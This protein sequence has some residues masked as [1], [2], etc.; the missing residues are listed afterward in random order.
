ML[1]TYDNVTTDDIGRRAEAWTRQ[2]L[3]RL[4]DDPAP[5]GKTRRLTGHF[6]FD[7]ILSSRDGELYPLECNARVHTAV[8]L[9][10]LDDIAE[11]YSDNPGSAPRDTLRPPHDSL[12]RSW[13]YNDLIMRYLPL[14]IP[15]H[16]LLA[17]LH[18]SLPACLLEYRTRH[19]LRPN[20]DPLK[21][22]VDPTLVADDWLPFLVLWHLWWP[23]VLMSRWWQGKK[24]TRVSRR[25]RRT[26][27]DSS[28]SA[29]HAQLNVSTGRIFEA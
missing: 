1:M 17:A 3:A 27:S 8:I 13:I 15:S 12:P 14:I 24:W 16:H 26:R 2:L 28:M 6:S 21:L 22:R 25:H 18:P 20:E 19:D 10:P 7:L 9:L 4:A 23:A 5:S 11:C 29:N